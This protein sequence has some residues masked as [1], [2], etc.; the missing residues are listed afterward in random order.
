MIEDKVKAR[1]ITVGNGFFI[2][3]Q[4]GNHRSR[5]SAAHWKLLFH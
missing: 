3:K 2:L 1:E 5:D 4:V